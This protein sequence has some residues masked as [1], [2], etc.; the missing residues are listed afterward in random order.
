VYSAVAVV[1]AFGGIATRAQ[2]LDAGLTGSDITRDV[3]LGSLRRVRRGHYATALA[4][5]DAVLAVRV[6][7]RLCATA[8]ARTYGFWG[9]F[10]ERLHVAV[11]PNASRLRLI[12]TDGEATPDIDDRSTVVHWIA[13]KA[14]RECWRVRPEDCVRHVVASADRETALACLDTAMDVM[15]WSHEY[16]LRLFADESAPSRLRAAQARP[17]SGSG[18]ESIATRRLRERGHR[19]RQQVVIPGVGRVDAL[20]DDH[21][22]LEIDGFSFHRSREAFETDRRRDAGALARA[23]PVIR[24]STRRIRHDWP[25]CLADI[26][27]ALLQFR[28][29]CGCCGQ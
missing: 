9:G 18:Y 17:G 20:V 28:K 13:A 6:G 7:G 14:A 16:L 5:R 24:L 26:E 27:A 1:N 3:R 11:A 22:V 25:G 10:D 29:S 4:D 12:R 21:L 19:V 8:A 2:I 15:G 23:L